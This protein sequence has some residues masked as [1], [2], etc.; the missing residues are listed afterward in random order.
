V[1]LEVVAVAEA[2]GAILMHNVADEGG[3][4]ALRKG[5]QLTEGHLGQLAEIGRARVRVAILEEGDCH[6]DEAA[7]RLAAALKTV[8]MTLS[9]AAGGRVNLG[10]QVNGL[11]EVD[12]DRLLELNVIPGIGLGTRPQHAV[13][14]PDQDSGNVA[15]LKIIP[16]ALPRRFLDAA[17]ELAQRRPGIVE[18]RPFQEGRRVAM[19]FVGEPSVHDKLRKSFLPATQARIER[20]KGKLVAT[21]AVVQEEEALGR[22]ATHL[23]GAADL[24]IIA[25]QT[26][27]M[28]EDDITLRALRAIGAE[29]TLSGAPVEPGN[30]LALAYFPGKAV[31]CAPGS[32]QSLKRNVMDLVLPRLLLGDRLERRD[33]AALGLGGF[34]TAAERGGTP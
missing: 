33:I 5:T 18:I 16:F 13:V 9:R 26:S 4:R 14:G 25:G 6:E 34:L 28:D 17:L 8:Q 32:A 7:T 12:A 19:L 3:A 31:V 21:E 20:L 10:A 15:T 29:S 24:V 1:R 22:A 27:I 23:L 11:L 2:L 30:L